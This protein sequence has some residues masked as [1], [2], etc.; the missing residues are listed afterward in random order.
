M[1]VH[2]IVTYV[3]VYDFTS[4]AYIDGRMALQLL[5]PRSFTSF[6]VFLDIPVKHTHP[7]I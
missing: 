2:T 7:D 5:I 1:Y 4:V 3:E 6:I